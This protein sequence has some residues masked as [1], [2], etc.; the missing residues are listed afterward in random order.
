MAHHGMGLGEALG[1][2]SD[3]VP[4]VGIEPAPFGKVKSLEN[5]DLLGS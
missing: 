3:L 1:A 4:R 2:I 5:A